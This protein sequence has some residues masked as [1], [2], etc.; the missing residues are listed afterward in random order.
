LISKHKGNLNEHLNKLGIYNLFDGIIHLKN[1]ENKS[2]YMMKDSFL[3]DD[4]FFERNQAREKGFIAFPVEF[5][6]SEC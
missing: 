5:F 1:N 4:S 3:I 6:Y 2:D